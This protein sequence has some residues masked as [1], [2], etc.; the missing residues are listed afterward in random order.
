[1]R[2]LRGGWLA[3]APPG[4]AALLVGA[5]V[6]SARAEGDVVKLGF[7][8]PRTGPYFAEGLD[9]LR[10]AELAVEEVNAQGGILGRKVALAVRDTQSEVPIT[11][12]NARELIAREN[13]TMLFGGSAS[14]EA[15]AMGEV[16]QEKGI[17]FFGTLTYS[18]ATTGSDGHRFTF[19]ECYNAWMG[20]KVLAKYLKA[21][22]AGKKYHYVTADYTWG[23][24][25]EES[26]RVFTGT[27]D[28]AV[29]KGTLTPF[30]KSTATDYRKALE[31]ARAESPDVL[32][33]VLFG[34]DMV[35]AVNIASGWGMKARMQ[36]VVP[37]LT[38]A[39]AE[40]AGPQNMSGVVGAVPWSWEIPYK[41]G[42]SKGVAFIE[43]FVAK[44]GRHPSCSGASAYVIVHEY[45]AAVERA[46][47]FAGAEVVKALEGHEYEGLKDKQVWRAFDHQS[48]QTV[49]AVR[50]NPPEVVNKDRF[51]QAF[52]DI[53]DVMSGD[54]AA[55]SRAEWEAERATAKRPLALEKLPGEQ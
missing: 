43:K 15:V 8:Y 4:L 14:S 52:F 53:L 38:L 34:Q 21:N 49:Y 54:E 5:V 18:N 9:E 13:V 26:V 35:N 6:A 45:K 24:T 7:N 17:P 22:F 1:M 29:H 28:K 16:A 31:A 25:T 10:G 37:N 41:Y 50:C 32:V 20:A 40:A 55:K 47:T 2:A 19:R 30:P 39:M 42:Y 44:H 36:I 48:V 51:R 33:L 27:T 12:A 11:T 23:W 3:I 46:K